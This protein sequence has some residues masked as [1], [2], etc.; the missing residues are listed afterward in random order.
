MCRLP[1]FK[2]PEAVRE[3]HTAVYVTFYGKKPDMRVGLIFRMSERLISTFDIRTKGYEYG[4][5]QSGDAEE[6]K[7]E[8]DQRKGNDS[9]RPLNLVCAQPACR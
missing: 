7:L 8:M 1:M 6:L 9:S 2:K 3:G 4:R 5:R